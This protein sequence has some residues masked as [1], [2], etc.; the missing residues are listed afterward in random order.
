MNLWIVFSAKNTNHNTSNGFYHMF[1]EKRF[2]FKHN[3]L[4]KYCF[5]Y[6][7][8]IYFFFLVIELNSFK[9]QYVSK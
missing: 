6:N 2:I 9:L 1:Q 7:I 4:T 3:G 5:L 8:Y